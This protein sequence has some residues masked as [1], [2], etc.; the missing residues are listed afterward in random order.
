[1]MRSMLTIIKLE[2][3]MPRNVRTT[4]IAVAAVGA[5]MALVLG[6]HVGG[7]AVLRFGLYSQLIGAF[8]GGFLAIVSVN[9]PLRRGENMEP[10]LGRERLAWTLIGAGCVMWGIGECFWRYFLVQGMNPFPSQADIGYSSL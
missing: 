2:V 6:L 3:D 10:W 5:V 4:L 1:M 8:I 7:S 9:Y